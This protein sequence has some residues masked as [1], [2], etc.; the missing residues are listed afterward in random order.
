MVI[1]CGLNKLVPDLGAAMANGGMSDVEMSMGAAI[2]LYNIYGSIIT[3]IKAFEMLYDVQAVAIAGSGIGS[4][5]GSRTFAL[6]GERENV[7][8]AWKGVASL[9]GAALSGV[10]ESMTTCVGG[11]ASCIRHTGCIY[12]YDAE[13]GLPQYPKDCM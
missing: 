9:K 3:E 2:E 11:C 4:G 6:L 5:A 13:H 12:K 1:L 8:N 7:Q 10:P